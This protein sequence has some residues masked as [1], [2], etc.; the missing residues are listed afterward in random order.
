MQDQE[1]NFWSDDDGNE[2]ASD[3]ALGK[4]PVIDSTFWSM[5]AEDECKDGVEQ[6]PSTNTDTLRTP[7]AASSSDAQL[8]TATDRKTLLKSESVFGNTFWDA[9]SDDEEEK[10]KSA[11]LIARVGTVHSEQTQMSRNERSGE[12]LEK[13]NTDD[14]D[15]NV[16][17]NG[18]WDPGAVQGGGRKQAAGVPNDGTPEGSADEN[19]ASTRQSV[20]AST[21][22]PAPPV[23]ESRSNSSSTGGEPCSAFIDTEGDGSGERVSEPT[24]P[25]VTTHTEVVGRAQTQIL[26]TGDESKHVVTTCVNIS[27][28]PSKSLQ[29]DAKVPPNRTIDENNVAQVPALSKSVPV[30]VMAQCKDLLRTI[31][32][33]R[34]FRSNLSV[35]ARRMQALIER[36]GGLVDAKINVVILKALGVV[37][38][39][40]NQLEKAA[41]SPRIANFKNGILETVNASLPD[42]KRATA[43]ELSQLLL[44][45]VPFD[46]KYLESVIKHGIGQHPVPSFAYMY[47]AARAALQKGCAKV[48][49][50]RKAIVE[51]L[52]KHSLFAQT[53]QVKESDLQALAKEVIFSKAGIQTGL[54]VENVLKGYSESCK[55]FSTIGELVQTTHDNLFK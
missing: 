45:S 8:N 49:T 53:M 23:P 38:E 10:Q 27:K 52:S 50:E 20:D 30:E 24:K 6:V 22:P 55:I 37:I 54:R 29:S 4:S 11:A 51:F 3:R 43:R 35:T 7:V 1:G 47:W 41:Q 19:Q 9:N 5:D 13:Q 44:M 26:D 18:F 16:F 28:R 40:W 33:S 25:T 32:A 17:G 12:T 2:R 21:L 39:D 14:A 42:A 36:S 46:I 34:L 48:P 15:E 31:S